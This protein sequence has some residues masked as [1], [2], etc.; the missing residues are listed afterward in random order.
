MSSKSSSWIGSNCLASWPG[1]GVAMA[2]AGVPIGVAP[3]E[4][5]MAT[6]V[7]GASPHLEALRGFFGGGTLNSGSASCCCCGCCGSALAVSG[8]AGRDGVVTSHRLRLVGAG[9]AGVIFGLG[10]S[11][12]CHL[13]V[14]H[15]GARNK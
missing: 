9:C 14:S 11:I 3:P 1:V 2:M 12:E 5:R 15:N 8:S 4:G 6:A 10:S 7:V 13:S